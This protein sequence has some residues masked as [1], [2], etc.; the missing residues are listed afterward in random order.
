MATLRERWD[1]FQAV[2][3]SEKNDG[4]WAGV[5]AGHP[6]FTTAVREDAT[7][8][9]RRRGERNEFDGPIDVVLQVLRLCVVTDAFLGQ[10]CYRAKAALQ[11]RRVPLLPRLF[12]R[13]AINQGQICIGDPVVIEAGVYF[14]HGQVVIDGITTLGRR[15]VVAPFTTIGLRSGDFVGPTILEGAQIGTGAKILGPLT[16]GE[17]AE[18]G[19]NSVVTKDVVAGDVV[20]G[21]PARVLRAKG[22]A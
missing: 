15:V 14:P 2:P 5:R 22:D 9:A 13:L 20:A 3:R 8:A 21:V 12:H 16:I 7:I 4:Y 10:V 11:A 18:V 6:P 1:H 17:N 19:A